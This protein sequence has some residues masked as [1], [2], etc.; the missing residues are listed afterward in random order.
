MTMRKLQRFKTD[1]LNSAKAR[2]RQPPDNEE[3]VRPLGGAPDTAIVLREFFN[4][5]YRSAHVKIFRVQLF[6]FHCRIKATA[7]F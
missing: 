5:Y 4:K 2:M 6:R 7:H 1:P 3:F